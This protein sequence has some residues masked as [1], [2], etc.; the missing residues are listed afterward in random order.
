[1]GAPLF[2]GGGGRGEGR[3]GGGGGEGISY[4]K[5]PPS[6]I[7]CTDRTP[8]PTKGVKVEVTTELD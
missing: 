5:V 2:G 4:P 8:M 6:N 3:G 1:M 7:F